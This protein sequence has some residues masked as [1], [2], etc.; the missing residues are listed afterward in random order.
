MKVIKTILSRRWLPATIIVIV[1]MVLMVRLGIWQLDRL[2][3]RRA[4]N[5]ALVEAVA[6]APLILTGEPLPQELDSL[7][8]REIT[9]V[10][11]F[12]FEQQVV[13]MVQ[14]WSGRAG[15]NLI[16]PFLLEGSDTAVLVDRGWVPQADVDDGRLAQYN[17]VGTIQ[18]AGTIALTQEL[19]Q[20]GN[21]AAQPKGPQAEV[22]RVDVDLLQAQLAYDILPVYV[23]QAPQGNEAPPFRQEP[24]IDLSEGP[25]L[26][27]AIQ[28]FL[29]TLIL[30]A[31]YF[32]YVNQTLK[33]DS[34]TVVPIRSRSR[35][36]D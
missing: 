32:I 27:Y 2:E 13:L 34:E 11:R 25:H 4:A 30:G 21:A 8:D 36:I 35:P 7:K 18:L 15:V 23:L 3:Q 6:A 33:K 31:G 24:E 5:A 22:Y 12:D 10:G 20:Y 26:S 29:F 16:T 1:G 19:S 14:N 17:E 9:A 28:W